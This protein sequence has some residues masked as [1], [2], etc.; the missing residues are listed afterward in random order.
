MLEQC[1]WGPPEVDS[2]CF[3][4]PSACG[5][6][7]P[8]SLHASVAQTLASSLPARLA[9]CR[10][11]PPLLACAAPPPPPP[12]PFRLRPG[13][14]LTGGSR[15]RGASLLARIHELAQ[16][17]EQLQA[18]QAAL[19]RAQGALQATAAAAGQYKK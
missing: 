7:T 18:A 12:P 5:A 10:R 6:C 4:R 11:L 9:C 3:V 8:A 15:N 14:T 16:A 17:E 19:A 13:G 2:A 1:R